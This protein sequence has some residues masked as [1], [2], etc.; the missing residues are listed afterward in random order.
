M[1]TMTE[2]ATKRL[3]RV[4]LQDL[5]GFIFD[6]DGVIYRGNVALPGAADLIAR[7]RRAAV[8]YLYL[9]NNS[10]TPADLVAERLAGMGIPTEPREVLTSAEVTAAT[11]ANQMPGGRVYLVGEEGIRRALLAAGFSLAADHREADLVVVGMDRQSTYAK[12]RESRAGHQ[13]R[14]AVFRHQHRPQPAHRGR[15]GSGRRVAG[16]DAGDCHRRPGH[17][18]R[19][20][21][22][23]YV[24]A[25]SAPLGH[26]RCV[27]RRRGRPA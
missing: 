6:M 19:Q 20:A 16:W 13:S 25:R 11:L 10:T 9:T 26:T 8:P 2:K 18:L 7:L 15:P 21:G 24:P 23:G 27:D 3:A 14:R 22:A 4:A 1:R 12:M 17:R 5:A